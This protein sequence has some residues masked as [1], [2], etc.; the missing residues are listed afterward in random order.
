MDWSEIVIKGLA[1]LAAVAGAVAAW[2]NWPRPRRRE[3]RSAIPS[4]TG[5]STLNDVSIRAGGDVN[6][7]NSF[8]RE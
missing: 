5:N 4:P 7:S 2:L 8:N 6:I 3:E 1:A